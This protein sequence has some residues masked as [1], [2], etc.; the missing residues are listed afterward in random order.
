M[1]KLHLAIDEDCRILACELTSPK[2][3][4]P[5]AV[6]DMLAQIEAPFEVSMGDDGR[7]GC[8]LT[9]KLHF[10]SLSFFFALWLEPPLL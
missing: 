10:I 1:R 6:T 9:G 4:D 2:V 8:R 3:G 5:T 7:H